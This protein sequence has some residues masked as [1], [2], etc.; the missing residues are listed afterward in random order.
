MQVKAA[1]LN[2]RDILSVLKP[3][4]QFDNSNSVAADYS[5]VVVRLGPDV[6]RF[7][8]GD[9]VLGCNWGGD[10]MPSHI[11]TREDLV[12]PLP[13]EFTFADGA[14]LATAFATAYHCLVTLA[15]LKKGETVLIHTASGK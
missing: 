3:D 8:I 10:A 15:N 2:F 7:K 9:P 5:G 6:K 4:A 11:C 12:V 14:T 13:D 1:G